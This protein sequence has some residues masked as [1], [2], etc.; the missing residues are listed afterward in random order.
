MPHHPDDD[1]GIP[2]VLGLHRTWLISQAVL[3]TAGASPI[4]TPADRLPTTVAARRHPQHDHLTP[5]PRHSCRTSRTRPSSAAG[6]HQQRG[7]YRDRDHPE[8]PGVTAVNNRSHTPCGPFEAVVRAPA[9]TFAAPR[10]MTR[11]PP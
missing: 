11:S 7:R 10:T 5:V 1:P 9:R 8:P 6:V 3:A 2:A 4:S